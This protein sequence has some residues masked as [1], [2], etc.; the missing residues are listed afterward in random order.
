MGELIHPCIDQEDKKPDLSCD[1]TGPAPT[2]PLA[3]VQG[4]G[5]NLTSTQV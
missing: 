4:A 3:F 2:V 1:D 5:Q